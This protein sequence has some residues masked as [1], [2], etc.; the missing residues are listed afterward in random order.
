M[1]IS[2]ET[3]WNVFTVLAPIFQEIENE[4]LIRMDIKRW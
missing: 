2:L 4:T 1:N 3:C